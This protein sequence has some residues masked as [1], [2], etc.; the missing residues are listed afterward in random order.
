M[1]IRNCK[2]LEEAYQTELFGRLLI[3][4]EAEGMIKENLERNLEMLID[5]Y[6]EDGIGGYIRIIPDSISTEE[7]QSEYLAELAKYKLEQEIIALK[8]WDALTGVNGLQSSAGTTN[9]FVELGSQM[10]KYIQAV[11]G[12]A[13]TAKFNIE[14]KANS[15]SFGIERNGSYIPFNLLSSGEK[16]MY[17]LALMI[18]LVAVSK[19]PLKIVMVDDLLDHLD[20]V[21]VTKLFESLQTVEDIQMIFA[22]VKVVN[23]EYVVEVA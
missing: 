15:F 2:E 11:F 18:S 10:D 9:P 8:Q 22:G 5:A 1:T 13:V 21:N 20:D 12:E 3:T 14:S 4:P 16:C 6:G 17:T 23:G 7:G 19:S